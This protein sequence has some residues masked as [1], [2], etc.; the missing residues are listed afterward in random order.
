MSRQRR[1][2]RRPVRSRHHPRSR[3]SNGQPHRV[4]VAFAPNRARALLAARFCPPGAP[5]SPGAARASRASVLRC[6]PPPCVER[7]PC[8]PKGLSGRTEFGARWGHPRRRRAR[9]TTMGR[10]TQGRPWH[11][12]YHEGARGA[13]THLFPRWAASRVRRSP[14]A[15]DS[16]EEGAPRW[17]ESALRRLYRGFFSRVAFFRPFAPRIRAER[18]VPPQPPSRAAVAPTRPACDTFRCNDRGDATRVV[19]L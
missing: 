10:P 13:E 19:V 5:A 15:E 12:R 2:T 9:T 4:S 18:V 7:A 1:L 14:R 3:A 8:A 11:R 16:A 6:P 17:K